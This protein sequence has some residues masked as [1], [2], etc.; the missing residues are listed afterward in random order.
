M[1]T[2]WGGCV[3]TSLSVTSIH[4]GVLPIRPI[5]WSS[6]QSMESN[7]SVESDNNCLNNDDY[8]GVSD[9]FTKQQL[10]E[11]LVHMGHKTGTWNPLMKPYILGERLGVHIINLDETKRHLVLSLNVLAHIVYRRGSVLFI[12]S[13]P[14]FDFLTQRTARE[15]GE[16]FVSSK[17]VPGS[18]TNRSKVL[19]SAWLPDVAV[20]LSTKCDKTAI[21]EVAMCNIPSIA[22]VDTD[23]NPQIIMYPI[24]GNDDSPAAVSF[25]CHIFKTTILLAKEKRRLNCTERVEDDR[26]EELNA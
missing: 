8:F 23:C 2:K 10:M 9:L 26:Q 12:H 14:E 7:I 20:F 22:V 3:L 15:C 4:V 18:L 24:P 25:F 19:D 5:T 1:C 16:M 21:K 6:V 13:R 11:N 17:W